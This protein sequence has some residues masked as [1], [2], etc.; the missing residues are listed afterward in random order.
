MS[1]EGTLVRLAQ[2]CV[3]DNRRWFPDQATSIAHHTLSMCGEAGEVANLVKKIERGDFDIR[4]TRTKNELAEELADVLI[5]ML[6]IAGMLHVDLEKVYNY[7]RAIN[8]RRFG[9]N[10]EGEKNGAKRVGTSG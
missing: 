1:E 7:K 2:Q 3:A 8:E 6:S 9:K 10:S 5:Y 4:D